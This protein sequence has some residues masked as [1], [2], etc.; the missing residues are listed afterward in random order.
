MAKSTKPAD[1]NQG[2]FRSSDDH[3]TALID[4][5]TFTAKAVQYC[6]V[7]GM[8]IVEGDICLGTVE[9]VEAHTAQRRAGIAAGLQA[10]VVISGTNFR[11][12]HCRIPYEIDSSLPNQQR[13]TDAIAHWEANTNYRFILRTSAN[14]ATY[15]D[16]VTFRPSSGCSSSVGRRGGQQFIN[17]GS[18]CSTGNAI[19][20]IG[21]TVG[22]WHEQSREDRDAFVTI[23]WSKIQ[24]GMEGN[25]LQRITDGDDVGACD[26][27]SIM[28]YP[29]TAFSIDGSETITPTDPT[30]VIGQRNGLSAGDIAA[31]NSLCTGPSVTIK[32]LDDIGTSKIADDPIGTRKF[33]DD[34]IGTRHKFFDDPIGTRKFTDDP[35]GTRNK[36][37]DDG[38]GTANKALDDVKAGGYDKPPYIDLRQPGGLRPW[39]RPG[40]GTRLPFGISTPHHHPGAI[41][42]GGAV[43]PGAEHAQVANAI[44]E[45][46][47]QLASI[48]VALAEAQASTSQLE[49]Q[50]YAIAAQLQ[51]MI[52]IYGQY[53]G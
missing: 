10:A 46:D 39:E 24:A 23:N 37:V 29:R 27:G 40:A 6:V 26:Y 11:W 14:A 38:V 30:A 35:I 43:Q 1:S 44:A 2:E 50:Y 4:G 20:E 48:E 32:A 34:P 31:A 52:A 19:H 13:V 53:G 25:F 22:L 15:P 45:L 16:Y 28:H 17:L 7:D 5:A 9:Q 3:R 33:I 21:H 47:Q 18:G 8:A 51:E 41:D 36:L 49:A 42:A 12:T